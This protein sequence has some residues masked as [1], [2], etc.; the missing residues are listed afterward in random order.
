[1]KAI[2]KTEILQTDG[3]VSKADFQSLQSLHFPLDLVSN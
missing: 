3:E 1:M 2:L